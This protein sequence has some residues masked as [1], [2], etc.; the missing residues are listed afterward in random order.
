VLASLFLRDWTPPAEDIL[1]LVAFNS[2][3][4]VLFGGIAAVARLDYLEARKVGIGNPA[5]IMDD[6]HWWRLFFTMW[7]AHWRLDDQFMGLY[8]YIGMAVLSLASVVAYFGYG[9]LKER[10]KGRSKWF[11]RVVVVATFSYFL[12]AWS[13]NVYVQHYGVPIIGH[14]LEPPHYQTTYVVLVRPAYSLEQLKA[15]NKLWRRT[16]T[17]AVIEVQQTSES[18]D[19]GEGRH[20]QPVSRWFDR[21]EVYVRRLHV[22]GYD[23]RVVD[24]TEPIGVG[25][26]TWVRDEN[27]NEWEIYL[28]NRPVR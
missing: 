13:K 16:K 23:V 19:Y 1:L 4:V 9:F 12:L 11:P 22:G 25:G 14:W 24:Q 27:G 21:S 15:D 6:G 5:L 7:I 17:T 10:E 8:V 3:S 2:I 20:G 28:S 26:S 18:V